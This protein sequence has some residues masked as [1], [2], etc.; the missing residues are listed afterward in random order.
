MGH[1][2]EVPNRCGRCVFQL[3]IKYIHISMNPCARGGEGKCGDI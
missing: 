3:Q 1:S 2:I